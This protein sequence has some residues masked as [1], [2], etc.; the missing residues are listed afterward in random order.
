MKYNKGHFY[1]TWIIFG[2]ICLFSSQQFIRL[3]NELFI[4]GGITINIKP[5]FLKYIKF[6]VYGII[7]LTLIVFSIRIIRQNETT[8]NLPNY[9]QVRKYF[10]IIIAI[11][12]IS[13]VAE[14]YLGMYRIGIFEKYL[15]RHSIEYKDIYQEL[16]IYPSMFW[17]FMFIYFA[18][19]FFI[20][21]KKIEKLQML[22][23][24]N[25]P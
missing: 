15:Q 19:L 20:L 6:L 5:E 4:V 8:E 25:N 18:V 12:I 17:T 1:L 10:L 14:N 23:A 16:F 9:N 24:N 2:M 21:T 13:I 11:G 3:L 7:A 22:T